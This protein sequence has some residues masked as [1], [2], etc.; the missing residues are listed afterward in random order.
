MSGIVL[1]DHIK[2]LCA[3]KR[4]TATIRSTDMFRD[5]STYKAEVQTGEILKGN[6]THE[7]QQ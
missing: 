1:I 5:P 6:K 4:P 2:L 3:R 7:S